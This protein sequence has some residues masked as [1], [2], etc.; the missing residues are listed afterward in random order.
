MQLPEGVEHESMIAALKKDLP[1][2]DATPLL[3]EA[4]S[5]YTELFQQADEVF[6][7]R[8]STYVAP[9][10]ESL[11]RRMATQDGGVAMQLPSIKQ[12]QVL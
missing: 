2:F 8:L 11:Q 4:E 6:E 10:A 9:N 3:Q 12:D 1:E 5:K 7:H